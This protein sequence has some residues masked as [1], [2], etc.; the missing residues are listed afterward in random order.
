[1]ILQQNYLQGG[2]S[3]Q[4]RIKI[5]FMRIFLSS[6]L[7]VTSIACESQV[8]SVIGTT[9]YPNNS[10]L[11]TAPDGKQVW[12]GLGDS[13]ADGR[14][15]TVPTVAANTLFLA[16][17]TGSSISEITTQ[18][19]ANDGTFG[20]MWQQYA[21]NKKANTGFVTVIVQRGA[22]GAEFWPNG[23]NTNWYVSGSL[24]ADAVTAA[25]NTLNLLSLDK[26]KGISINLG[27]NDARGAQSLT[28]I[29]TGVNSLIDRLM[30]DFPNTPI[31][32]ISIGRM[33]GQF[34]TERIA[35]VKGNIKDMST[36]HS[37]V[38]LYA[39]MTCFSDWG[40]YQGDGLHLTT[41]GYNKAGEMLERYERSTESNKIVR[42]VIN[43]FYNDL[44]ST[45]KAAIKTF[46]EGCITDGNWDATTMDS[47]QFFHPTDIRD[48]VPDWCLISSGRRRGNCTGDGTNFIITDGVSGTSWSTNWAPI[49]ARRASQNDFVKGV[50]TGTVTTAAGI[51]AHL[52][53]DGT[54]MVLRSSSS[55]VITYNS[56][57][58]TGST[59]TGGDTQFQNN[60]DYGNGRSSSSTQ[61][62]FKAGSQVHSGSTTSNTPDIATIQ[63]GANSSDQLPMAVEAKYHFY[64]KLS[65]FT[66]SSFISRINTLISSWQN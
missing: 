38:H 5:D 62:L 2:F 50:R 9:I 20:S 1:M 13:N 32:I 34:I 47:F 8:R 56:N 26:L 61:I 57:S 37:N 36:T 44:S 14:G 45:N 55:N 33:E 3:Q 66:Y 18:D 59:W 51:A 15:E 49:Y 46:V 28:D 23:D 22:G 6:L 19:V 63:I 42:Q 31:Y 60:T 7:F 58:G 29:Q 30:V 11:D 64:G 53:S 41:A 12:L 43:Q 48:K 27:I 54:N 10:Q 35:S 16:N 39:N 25:K 4:P 40:F 65:T 17:S 21:T 52:H 24:Y